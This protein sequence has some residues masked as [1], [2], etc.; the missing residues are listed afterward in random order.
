MYVFNSQIYSLVLYEPSCHSQET[1]HLLH[2]ILLPL[3]EGPVVDGR[4]GTFHSVVWRF[5]TGH[6]LTHK[7]LDV[8]FIPYIKSQDIH[9]YLTLFFSFSG[10]VVS[11][12]HTLLA[13]TTILCSL[14]HFFFL[15]F[16]IKCNHAINWCGN[17]T[18]SRTK[19]NISIC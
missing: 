13:P 17:H 8:S 5:C 3:L 11:V 16:G 1:R 18:E 12:K 15:P 10:T 7:K 19:T 4:N 6:H 14:Y 2:S 9:P